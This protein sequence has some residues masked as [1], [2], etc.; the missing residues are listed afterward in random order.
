VHL[1]TAIDAS[2]RRLGTDRIDLLQ[3]HAHD[4]LNPFD[5]TLRTLDDAVRAGKVR[6]LGCSNLFA[7][8]L[9]KARAVADARGLEPFASVQAY[10]SVAGRDIERE[11]IPPSSISSSACCRGVRWPGDC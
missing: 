6:Y 3:L 2:L 10:Y 4:P 9:V 1:Q 11:I 5:D 7:W 8:Q